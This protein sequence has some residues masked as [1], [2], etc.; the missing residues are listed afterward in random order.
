MLIPDDNDGPIT[1]LG[2]IVATLDGETNL[3]PA[4]IGLKSTIRVAQLLLRAASGAAY[5]SKT[6]AEHR[7]HLSEIIRAIVAGL[8]A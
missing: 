1:Y 3:E 5:D 4:R 8:R 2:M 7:R 6:T